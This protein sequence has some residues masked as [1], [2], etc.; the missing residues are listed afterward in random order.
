MKQHD[1]SYWEALAERYFQ[2]ETTEAEARELAAYA[3]ERGVGLRTLAAGFGW[4]KW[5]CSDDPEERNDAVKALFGG[6]VNEFAGLLLA[7]E[8]AVY[9]SVECYVVHSG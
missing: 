2:A 5:L 7:P 9:P 3:K 8:S 4:G 1:L 6:P